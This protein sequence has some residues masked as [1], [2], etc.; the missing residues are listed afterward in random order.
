MSGDPGHRVPGRRLFRFWRRDPDLDVRDELQFHLDASLDEGL[1]AGLDRD[2]ARAEALRRFGDVANVAHRLRSL[3]AEGERIMYRKEWWSTVAQDFRF[4][5]RQLRRNPG[6]TVIILVTLAL[7]IGANTAIFSIVDSVLL[8]PLPFA[9]PD[10]I[11]NLRQDTGSP[12]GTFVPFPNFLKWES[13]THQFAALGGTV[14]QFFT[15]T[16]AGDPQRLHGHRASAGYWKVLRI[17]PALGRYYTAADDRYGGPKVV[18]LSHALWQSA[19]GGDSSIIGRDIPLD[20][21]PYTVVAVAP[22][23]YSVMPQSPQFWVPLASPPD[24][25][26][27]YFDHELTVVGLLKPGATVA[28]GVRELSGIEAA[29]QT[30]QPD[31]GVTGA[32]VAQP[33][34]NTIVGD[35]RQEYLILFG[36][37]GLVLLISCSNVVN[38]LLARSLTRR[39][40]FTVR[41]ALGAGSGRIVSQLL[42]ESAVLAIGGALLGIGVAAAGIRFLVANTPA[43]VPRIQNAS[44]NAT[45]LMFTA[46]VTVLAAL[47]F[48]LIPARR[49][50]RTDLQAA[51]RE[52]G[53]ESRRQGRDRLRAGLIVAEIAV[54]MVL[55]TGAGVLVRSALLMQRVPPGFDPTNVLTLRI[56]LPAT[57]YSSDTLV[58]AA[59]TDIAAQARTIPGVTSAAMISRIPIGNGGADCAARAAGLPESPGTLHDANFRPVTPR[60]FATM[61]TPILR[62]RD[63]TSADAS[64][65]PLVVVINATLAHKLFGSADP[66]GKQLVHCVGATAAGPP[67]RTVVG[68]IAD[69]HADGLT[70]DAPSE[71]YYPQTQLI[72]HTMTLV[73]RGQVPVGTLL[74]V[75]RRTI[76]RIDAQLPLANVATMTD[77]MR[78]ASADLYFSTLLLAML[79][80]IGLLLAAVGTYGVIGYFVTERAHEMGIRMALGASAWRVRTMVVR[81]GIALALA[82]VA[83]GGIGAALA[84]RVLAGLVYGVSVRDTDTFIAVAVLLAATGLAASFV[85]AWRATRIDPLTALRT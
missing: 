22:P 2:A 15:L 20:G 10:R 14:W 61:R 71:I 63:F 23:G 43:G 79:G 25:A 80:G 19:F 74:P 37:V 64:G 59:F 3:T 66:I 4:G 84:T 49:A 12:G 47:V 24:E 54:A 62:G 30:P 36:A 31:R 67:A 52:G 83:V 8:K 5:I 46:I 33:M 35:A 39:A 41:S 29:I 9:Q 34:I 69:V 32:V 70:F 48:G 13:D 11:V 55:L 45:V 21:V 40:E 68:V 81:Q 75:L 51:L 73:I 82:G 58:A 78:R 18:V 72:D 65:A 56:G 42:V 16:G 7:G 77:V 26:G 17:A 50:S 1:A 53:R 38:L 6:F 44:L 85:P 60:Y 76:A 57:R 27:R 28:G